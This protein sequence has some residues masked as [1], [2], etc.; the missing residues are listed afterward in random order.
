MEDVLSPSCIDVVGDLP[1]GTH[2][3]HFYD[4]EQDLLDFQVPYFKA[5]LE[6]NEHCIWVTSGHITV[7]KAISALRKAV[8][9]LDHYLT[10]GSIEIVSHVDWY[11]EHGKFELNSSLQIIL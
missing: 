9:D 11:M 10:R 4:T 2:F 6:N 3:C 1:W 7:E 5:G 8:P